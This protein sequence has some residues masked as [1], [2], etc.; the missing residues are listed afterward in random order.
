MRDQVSQ[1]QVIGAVG[2]SGGVS[3]PQLHFE[4]RYAPNPREKAAPVDPL[5]ILR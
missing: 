2:T 5:P 3:Q 4:I 1:G